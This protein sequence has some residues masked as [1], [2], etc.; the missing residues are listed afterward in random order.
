M[1][2]AGF[3]SVTHENLTGGSSPSTAGS[4]RRDAPREETK[5]EQRRVNDDYF[6]K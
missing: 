2:D 3:A 5:G 1:I 4:S 6:S